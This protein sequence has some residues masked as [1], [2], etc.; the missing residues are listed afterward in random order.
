MTIS[1]R[2]FEWMKRRNP[3]TVAL[4]FTLLVAII[5]IVGALS[6]I[7]FCGIVTIT[8][9]IFCLYLL[10][11]L[12]VFISSRMSRMF[13]GSEAEEAENNDEHDT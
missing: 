8:V 4:G 9:V 11:R 13:I 2:I 5:A 6:H 7:V 3:N 1:G 12:F 10:K